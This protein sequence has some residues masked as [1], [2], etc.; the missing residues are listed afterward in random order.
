MNDSSS[1]R[2]PEPAH[3][4]RLLLMRQ[5]VDAASVPSARALAAATGRELDEIQAAFR[6]LAQR[7]V[8]ALEPGSD[9]LRMVHPFSAVPT[10][11]AVHLGARR[12]FGNC[13]W[14]ALGIA[15]LF[16]EPAR[17]ETACPDCGER[18]TVASDGRGGLEGAGVVHFGVPAARW[19]ENIIF[20]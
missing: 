19:Y 4:V 2:L 13:A 16:A 18:L 17:V 9:E 8:V 3:S 7:H 5:I 14:D 6:D 20:T 11:W 10:P 12:W 1:P 15:A